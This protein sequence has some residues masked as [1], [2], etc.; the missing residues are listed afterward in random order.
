MS[1]KD[2]REYRTSHG[3]IESI[4]RT[5]TREDSYELTASDYVPISPGWL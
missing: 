2:G 5:G 1:K 3:T 4:E